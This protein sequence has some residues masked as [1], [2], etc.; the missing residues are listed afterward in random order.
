MTGFGPI[1]SAPVGGAPLAL[2]QFERGRKIVSL[3]STAILIPERETAEGLLVKSYGA[4]WVEVA[5]V[6][7]DDWNVAFQID[8][9]LSG[10]FSPFQNLNSLD[11]TKS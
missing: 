4:A 7:G 10:F 1:G 2:D 5:R 9:H 8:P 6:L 3:T 11:D